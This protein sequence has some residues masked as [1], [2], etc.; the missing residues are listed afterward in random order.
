MR[1]E[2]KKGKEKEED[3]IRIFKSLSR[4]ESWKNYET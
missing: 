2:S 1:I 4:R 3:L